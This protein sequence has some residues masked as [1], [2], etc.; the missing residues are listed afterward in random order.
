M[1]EALA[2]GILLGG[3]SGLAPGPLMTLMLLETIRSGLK[4][5]IKVALVPLITDG[6]IIVGII[7]L[8]G[9]IPNREFFL[10]ILSLLGG[11]VILAIAWK[12]ANM[13]PLELPEEG[14]RLQS[15]ALRQ[16]ILVNF[17]SPHP[18]LFWFSVGVPLYFS[19]AAQND[20]A[21]FG[22]SG[23]VFIISFY[24]TL[25]AVKLAIAATAFQFRSFFQGKA[26]LVT[27]KILAL[28]LGWFAFVLVRDGVSYLI[29]FV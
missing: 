24:V 23:I 11:L 21:E 2:K 10:A 19:L 15:S 5:G 9:Y 12:T 26:Y 1:I 7:Y 28:C 29:K 25:I 8:F 20:T 3:S 18:Y 16:G 17:F 27:T 14:G 22:S 6:P 13:P 4:N